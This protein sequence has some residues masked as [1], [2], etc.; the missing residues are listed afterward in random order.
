MDDLFE[1]AKLFLPKYLTPSDQEQL[2]SE[3]S[4]FSST[5]PFYLPPGAVAHELLQGDGWR[6][7]VLLDFETLDRQIVSGL[8][9]SNSCDIDP[10]NE[11]ALPTSVLFAPLISLEKYR[12]M[13]VGAGRTTQQIDDTVDSIRSQRV[14]YIFYLPPGPYGPVESMVLLHDI[15]QQPLQ[16]F[17]N[18]DRTRLFRLNQFG[19]WF[20]L[21]KLSI[22]FCRF[23][24]GVRRFAS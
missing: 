4:S 5:K 12:A 18:G 22:H 11:R 9:L 13:L 23:Q 20:L 15:H 8:I 6:G 17:L 10:A 7:F 21:V 24:E 14:T 1:Q 16:R 3:I 19:F 2:Y